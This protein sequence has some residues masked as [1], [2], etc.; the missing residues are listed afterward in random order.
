MPDRPFA[1]RPSV[2]DGRRGERLD[3]R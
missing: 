1:S 2:D 3:H